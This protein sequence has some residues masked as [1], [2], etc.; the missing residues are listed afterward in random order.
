MSELEKMF[1]E[2][3]EL[4]TLPTAEEL[5]DLSLLVERQLK[6]KIEM[7][8][9]SDYLKILTERHDGLIDVAIP[10]LMASTGMTNFTLANGVK[11]TIKEDVRASMRADF[12]EQAVEWL[13]S[14]N[15]GGIV[16]DEVKVNFGRGEKNSAHMLMEYCKANNFA[17]NE[18][19]S[20]HPMT[21]KAT[22][23]EQLGKGIQFPEEF[24]SI[25]PLR[26]AVIK[27]AK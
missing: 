9:V 3:A 20:I 6:L 17:A 22:V 16:K 25:Q 15:L 27:G 8:K 4:K 23:K 19:M 10:D 26:K 14:Q 5:N 21:L 11:I 24:F 2:D 7:T 18:K 12:I 13:D 1:Q